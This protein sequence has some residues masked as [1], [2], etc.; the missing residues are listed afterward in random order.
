[1]LGNDRI[2]ADS[3]YFPVLK[4]SAV[5]TIRD[6]LT[7]A[8]LSEFIEVFE[9]NRITLADLPDLTDAD[10]TETFGMDRFVDRKRFKAAILAQQPVSVPA[11]ALTPWYYAGADATAR[12]LSVADIVSA[13]LA[14]PHERHLVWTEGMGEWLPYPDVPTLATLVQSAMEAAAG[15]VRSEPRGPARSP[16]RAAEAS[17][18]RPAGLPPVSAFDAGITQFDAVNA[19]EFTLA[20][21]ERADLPVGAAWV[22]SQAIIARARD[23]LRSGGAFGIR[24]FGAIRASMRRAYKVNNPRN[25]RLI[26]VPARRL[27]AFVAARWLRP[28][29]KSVVLKKL[30]GERDPVR[31]LS[32]WAPTALSGPTGKVVTPKRAAPKL[33]VSPTDP[34]V[35]R[36]TNTRRS[37]ALY[38]HQQSGMPL[39]WAVRLVHAWIYV[40]VDG[41][42]SG[43]GARVPN[44]GHFVVVR[45][46]ERMIRH[47][48]TGKRIKLGA[49]T[50]MHLR[51]SPRFVAGIASG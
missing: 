45:R 40:I 6:F 14:A 16:E 41:V 37:L 50:T 38:V 31:S 34:R 25:G 8:D 10:L 36:M 3:C 21:A 47:P 7:Y 39:S 15:A 28:L 22:A 9:H 44:L 13:V 24:G 23:V 32:F 48:Q 17:T 1:M 18:P 33:V 51:F 35:S 49:R 2:A 46:R 5:L 43:E 19:G 4:L 26:T 30:G 20:L 11:A 12:V 42:V 27:P 29:P